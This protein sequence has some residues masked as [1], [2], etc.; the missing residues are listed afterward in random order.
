[1]TDTAEIHHVC[2]NCLRKHPES[3]MWSGQAIADGQIFWYCKDTVICGQKADRNK[4]ALNDQARADRESFPE[5]SDADEEMLNDV[6][7]VAE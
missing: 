5:D 2:L 1:M 4:Q 6:G 7:E 3:E